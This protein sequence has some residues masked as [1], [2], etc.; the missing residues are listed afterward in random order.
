MKKLIFSLLA[1]FMLTIPITAFAVDAPNIVFTKNTDGKYIYCNNAEFIMRDDLADVSNKKAKYIMNNIDMTANKY[2]MFISHINHTEI[3][4]GKLWTISEPGF[5]IQLDVVFKAKED[6]K[7][8]ITALGFE[9]PENLTYW[10]NG[11]LYSSEEPWGCINAWAD[12]LQLPIRQINS[13]NAYIPRNFEPVTIEIK[14]GEDMWLSKY[15][16]NYAEVPLYRPVHLMADFEILSG[17]CDINVAALK[18]TGTLGDRSNI[19]SDIAFGAY[20]RERQYKGVADSLNEV[21]TEL[22]YTIDDELSTGSTLPVNIINQFSPEGKIY[23]YWF[24]N[25][26]PRAFDWTMDVCTESDMMEFKYYDPSKKNYYGKNVKDEDKDDIWYFD[27]YHNDTSDY[28]DTGLDSKKTYV[29]NR[30]L[31]LDNSNYSCNLGNYGVIYNYKITVNNQGETTRYINY[32][33]STPS[34]NIVILR[35][36][37]GNMIN[38]YAICKGVNTINKEDTLACIELPAKKETTFNMQVILTTNYNGGMGSTLSITDT[39]TAVETYSSNAQKITEE[40]NYSGKEFYKWQNGSLMISEDL[41][42]WT[43]VSLPASVVKAMEGVWNEYKL[44]YT[45]EGYVIKPGMYDG[46]PYYTARDW[47]TTVYFLDENFNY[48]TSHK[49]KNYPSSFSSANGVVYINAGTPLYSDTHSSD[50]KEWKYSELD[51]LPCDNYGKFSAV[52]DNK[53]VRLSTDGLEFK[54]VNYSDF[55]PKFIDSLGDLYYYT[56]NNTL[57]LSTDGLYWNEIKTKEPVS[58]IYRTADTIIVNRNEEYDIPEFEDNISIVLNDEFIV[59]KTPPVIYEGSTFVPLRFLA[60]KL[61]AEV[62]WN[63]GIIT[64]VKDNKFIV[65]NVGSDKAKINEKE[66]TITHSPVIINDI[67]FVPIRFI[68][69]SFGLDVS[70]DNELKMITLTETKND[71]MPID[72]SKS[73]QA[74]NEQQIVSEKNNIKNES[75][76]LIYIENAENQTDTETEKTE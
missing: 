57:Y 54:K 58:Y 72:E 71:D 40:Y 1:V 4:D 3:D 30:L 44:L 73:T 38:P 42:N 68:S 15:I 23:Y 62:E 27:V 22:Y 12:Y 56:E 50:R 6:T 76:T 61:N 28:M 24:T 35:D 18:S 45:G 46:V 49:F 60:E 47:Y 59:P 37:D 55:E 9:V 13:G 74:D 32:N 21:S 52:V 8:V 16:P 69:E 25:Y 17:K 29:P 63:D 36:E 20:E 65:L 67:S 75:N 14:A 43:Q 41:E 31:P 5:D 70:W 53:S 34:N 19:A 11:K 2:A 10:Q 7:L 26:N 66:T 64:I 33:L 48:V 51:N 39:P